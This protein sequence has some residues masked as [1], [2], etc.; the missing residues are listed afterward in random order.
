[1]TVRLAPTALALALAACTAPAPSGDAGRADSA[2]VMA[3][4]LPPARLAAYHW[5][6]A[7]ATDGGQQAIPALL[8]NPDRPLRLAFA[9]GTLQVHNGCNR[10]GGRYR[11]EGTM[12]RT[13]ALT[14][15]LMAC[16]DRRLMDADAAIAARLEAE[17]TLQL[18][19]R[20][21][22]QLILRTGAG[23]VL[24][25]NGVATP[26]TR[27]RGPGTLMFFEVDAQRKPC[28]HPLIP[29]MQCLQVRERQYDARGLIVGTPGPWQ[30]LYQEI[31]GFEHV[32]GQQNVLRV[33]RYD[34]ANP[35][36]DAPAVAYVLDL[37]VESQVVD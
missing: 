7:S 25:F 10:I 28:P 33:K 15:T 22:P 8:P 34:V 16:A 9:G 13:A 21:P 27:Y 32:P 4:S 18:D 24:T 1:M 36:A 35:P 30:P 31:E 20:E 37:V 11:L 2:S 19:G 14:Q 5:D 12:L 6:L 23:D 3:A 29:D 26:E 17:P